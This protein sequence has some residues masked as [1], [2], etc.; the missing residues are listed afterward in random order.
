MHGHVSSRRCVSAVSLLSQG[1]VSGMLRVH[2][3][4]ATWTGPSGTTSCGA[5]MCTVR[6]GTA[7][8]CHVRLLSTGHVAGVSEELNLSFYFELIN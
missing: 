6:S 2:G 1:A 5:D 7:V 4:G 8:T 3:T